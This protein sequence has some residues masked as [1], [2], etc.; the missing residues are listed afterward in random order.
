[1]SLLGRQ[2]AGGAIRDI[3]K[4]LRLALAPFQYTAA[5]QDRYVKFLNK[6]IRRVNENDLVAPPPQILGPVVEAIRYEPDDTPVSDMF[7]ELLSKAFD[8]SQVAKAHP[9]YPTII[10]QLSSD[11]ALML[12]LLWQRRPHP[13]YKRT[14]TMVLDSSRRQWINPVIEMEEFPISVLT[15]PA[16]LNFYIDHLLSLGLAGLFKEYDQPINENGTQT[17]LRLV[18]SLKL[19]PM[20]ERL[21]EAASPPSPI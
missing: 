9:S 4:T 1:L 20:G 6:S 18:Q 5:L 13:P 2:E 8:S 12:R 15:F 19:S 11:E 10:R 7:S 3:V 17:G 14:S 21:M 16:N